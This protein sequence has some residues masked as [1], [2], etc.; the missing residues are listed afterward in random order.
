[1]KN[2]YILTKHFWISCAH[3]VPGAGKC[4]RLHGH[5]YKVTFC[6]AGAELNQ[7]G[8]LID[9]RDV[10]HLIEKKFDHNFLNDFEEFQ[11]VP[12]TTEKVAEVFYSI[13]D[14][15]CNAKENKPFLQ[16]VEIE[17]TNEARVRYKKT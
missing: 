12:P 3:R 2:N 10:K 14:N 7:N 1:M 13:I 16:W 9:F 5:N 15:L 17:E 11:E 6:V 4:E 8:M